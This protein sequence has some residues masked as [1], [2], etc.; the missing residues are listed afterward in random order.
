LACLR[1]QHQTTQQMTPS[2]ATPPATESPI[3]VLCDMRV[4]A[5]VF[6]VP[7]DGTT[8]KLVPE[9]VGSPL[10]VDICVGVT[11]LPPGSLPAGDEGVAAGELGVALLLF[12]RDWLEFV[13]G[14]VGA[15]VGGGVEGVAVGV[16]G[17]VGGGS[18][19]VLDVRVGVVNVVGGWEVDIIDVGRE[20][21]VA[22]PLVAPPFVA[23]PFVAPPFVTPPFVA[24]PFVAPP[25]VAP[26]FVAPPCVAPPLTVPPSSPPRARSRI[27]SRA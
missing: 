16:D 10:M 14:G 22:P 25:F 21:I 7:L 19:G 13:D 1:T 3:M 12:G 23:P 6:G 8:A 18:K 5:L 9:P 15:T 2:T 4:G 17:T 26:P 27:P 24:P 20:A 11:A